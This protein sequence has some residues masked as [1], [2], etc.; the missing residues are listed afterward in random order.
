MKKSQLIKILK[1]QVKQVKEQAEFA[2]QA[3]SQTIGSVDLYELETKI[4]K[5]YGDKGLQA[6]GDLTW[7][8]DGPVSGFVFISRAFKLASLGHYPPDMLANIVAEFVKLSGVRL[9]EDSSQQLNEMDLATV[10]TVAFI[11]SIIGASAPLLG[12]ASGA[13]L[14]S[15]LIKKYGSV[16]KG[17]VG[18]AKDMWEDY[19]DDQKLK[20][21]LLRLKGDEDLKPFLKD[22]NKKG[23]RKVV[24]TKLSEEELRYLTRITRDHL[25]K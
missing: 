20:E 7:E 10:A 21:I 14:K 13:G 17:L 18:V 1:E 16:S 2:G 6:F 9:E 24:A 15:H 11:S 12:Y 5:L 23:I 25:S 8:G 3:S 22:P 4:D 19:K